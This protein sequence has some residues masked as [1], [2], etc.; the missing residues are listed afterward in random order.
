MRLHRQC[1]LNHLHYTTGIQTGRE[2]EYS[3]LEAMPWHKQGGRCSSVPTDPIPHT[4]H[5][6]QSPADGTRCSGS[7]QHALG[8]CWCSHRCTDASTSMCH[9]QGLQW[10]RAEVRVVPRAEPPNARWWQWDSRGIPRR[11]QNRIGSWFKFIPPHF[12]AGTTGS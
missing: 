1:F 6:V 7:S 5:G 9:T 10:S 12:Q 4:C 3:R 2:H 8:G 11:K